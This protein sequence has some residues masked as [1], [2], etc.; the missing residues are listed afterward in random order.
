MAKDEKKL[1]EELVKRG[2]KISKAE[3]MQLLIK[4]QRGF[5]RKKRQMV[6][7]KEPIMFLKRRN[8]DLEFHDNVTKGSF[9]FTHSDGS[10]RF[11]EIRPQ[12]QLKFV[13]GDRR[14]RCYFGDEDRPFT[15]SA[16]SGV[17]AESIMTAINR[18]NATKLKYEESLLR[19]KRKGMA[20]WIWII[21]AIAG[22]IG[23][24]IFALG[25]WGGPILDKVGSS[26]AP[27]PS[28]P[29]LIFLLRIAKGKVFNTEVL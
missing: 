5:L 3:K 9:V 14:V 25:S 12:D 19:E 8:G 17:D 23:F 16:N 2:H 7:F 4:I 13:Y 1:L 22:A 10:P 27:P 28:L 15:G 21:L 18:V 20:K 11:M 26:S 29:G 6:D 24:V